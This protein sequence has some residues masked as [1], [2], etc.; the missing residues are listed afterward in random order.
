MTFMKPRVPSRVIA[1]LQAACLFVGLVLLLAA[2][3]R[4][5]A[6]GSVVILPTTGVVDQVLAGYLNDAIALAH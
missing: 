6:P 3:T 4:A 1:S 2:P 5:A